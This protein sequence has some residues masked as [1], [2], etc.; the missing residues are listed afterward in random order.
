MEIIIRDAVNNIVL[1]TIIKDTAKWVKEVMPDQFTDYIEVAFSTD[2]FIDIKR[3]YTSVFYGVK[4]A[5][6]DDVVPVKDNNTGGFNYTI[7]FVTPEN[8]YLSN[9]I[10]WFDS[11][12]HKESDFTITGTADLLVQVIR[13]NLSIA[14]GRI[15]VAGELPSG[16]ATVTFTNATIKTGLNLIA[17]AFKTEWWINGLAINISECRVGTERI[18]NYDIELD[19]ISTS[20]SSKEIL[21]KIYAYGATRNVPL[22]Y[23]GT[24]GINI[25]TPNRLRLPAGHQ[26]IQLN[27]GEKAPK[28][29]VIIFDN[30]Y[31]RRIGSVSEVRTLVITDNGITTTTY[32][33][34]DNSVLFDA[35]SR[36]KGQTLKAVF[37]SGYLNGRD[38]DIEL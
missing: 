4:Y 22:A 13:E 12:N 30:I 26:F 20:N 25:S 18:L 23:Y 10:L 36:T 33:F 24:V 9:S 15:F 5:V 19:E 8:L 34:K 27:P 3:A 28:E 2:T 32:F 11:T 38:F 21:T 1:T 16:V 37:Q 35:L 6:F 14:D 29:G 7:T 17:E 31:P